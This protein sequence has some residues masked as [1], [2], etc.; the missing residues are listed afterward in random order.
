MISSVGFRA[1]KYAGIVSSGFAVLQLGGSSAIGCFTSLHKEMDK[2]V[3]DVSELAR[4]AKHGLASL[5]LPS[6][7]ENITARQR[8]S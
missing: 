3:S 7:Y 5:F 1:P 8:I 4:N 2:R 6:R